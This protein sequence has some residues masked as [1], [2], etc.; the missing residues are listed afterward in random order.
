MEIVN[1]II[2]LLSGLAG[3]NLTGSAFKEKALSTLW[4]SVIGLLGGAGGGYLTTLLDLFHK[5]GANIDPN[6]AA[7]T[8]VTGSEFDIGSILANVVGGGAGGAILTAIVT[9]L[10]NTLKV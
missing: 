2:S 1:L 9:W 5:A 8:P 3:G 7:N 10:K 4:N 6:V